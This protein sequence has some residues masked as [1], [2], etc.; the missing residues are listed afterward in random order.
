MI[1]KLL[2]SV[3]LTAFVGMQAASAQS[4]CENFKMYYVNIPAGGPAEGNS[5]LYEGEIDETGTAV[6]LTELTSFAGGAHIALTTEGTLYVV[7]VNGVLYDYDTA[8]NTP[9]AGEQITVDGED[10]TNIPHAVADPTDGTL[11]VASANTN[12]VY[13]V[14]PLTAEA[15]LVQALDVDVRGGDL[16]ITN[17]G[18]LW[19]AN[20][21]D[22][23]FYNISA[24]GVPGFS[25][26]LNNINGAGVLADGTIIVSN[27]GS[28][29]FNLIDPMTG[30]VL[31]NVLETEI[32]FG[33]G[34]IAAACVTGDDIVIP[35]CF[36]AEVLDF[37]QGPQTNGQPVA[38]DRSDPN[39]VLGE[40][41]LDN[42]AGNFFSL[43]VGGFI[44]IA[45]DGIVPDLPGNDILVVETSF[46]GDECGF[47]DDEFAD[48]E[49]TQDGINW[50]E[51]GTICRNEEIDIAVTGLEFV[52]AIRIINSAITTTLD[53][54]DLD[55]VIALQ[56]CEPNDFDIPEGECYATEVLVYDPVGPI[57]ADRMDPTQALGEPERDNTINF[58]S[59]GF[60]GS[61]ILGFDG[62]APALPDVD[63]LEVVETT[64]GNNDCVSFEERAD[65]YVSQQ[66]VNDP[67]E[68]DDALFVYVGQSCTNGEFFDVHAE[69]G[70]DYFTLVK[71][72]D[73]TP[74]EAQLPG[75]DG[76][77]VD[78]IVLIHNCDE[79]QPT[80]SAPL[81]ATGGSVVMETFPNPSVGHVNVEFVSDKNNLVT[82]EV[83]DMNGRIV[84]TLFRQNANAGQE[85]R[86]SFEGSNLPN[87]VYITKLTTESE[88]VIKKV[89]IAR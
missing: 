9:S 15:T 86:L 17:D 70:F 44:D 4:D 85:Y 29:V 31:P 49:L 81:E 42:S 73:V 13:S 59:L 60:G 33:N 80:P 41:S 2:F 3:S 82:V 50:V 26:A 8:T 38:A 68:I 16:V 54:Y 39:V 1:K 43:G 63:D 89:L 25:T 34:D 67:S 28:T 57:A 52:V 83:I 62:F 53:G 19:L 56:G 24:G 72:V 21:F 71:I 5:I 36:G 18:I 48:I 66:V 6:M 58:V 7:G 32:T 79:Y 78:G 74:E 51:Y 46:S 61:L 47:S 65:V 30:E 76:Y 35:G 87:G 23:T 77:D 37:F 27:A 69:T 11:Y 75:R 84:E 22:N 45:F 88:V 40:P 12:A 14:D 64:F 10:L 20:R 55:G